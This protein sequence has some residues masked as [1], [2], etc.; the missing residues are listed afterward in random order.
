MSFQLLESSS[1]AFFSVLPFSLAR[2]SV[3][4]IWFIIGCLFVCLRGCYCCSVG[5][6][7]A[8]GEVVAVDFGKTHG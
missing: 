3:S 8:V 1:I 6:V 7:V 2:S 5:G 4:L